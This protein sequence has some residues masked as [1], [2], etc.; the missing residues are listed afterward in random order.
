MSE[1]ERILDDMEAPNQPTY[2]QR[3]VAELDSIAAAFA[4]IL[5]ASAINNVE[6]NRG[7][8]GSGMVFLGFAKWG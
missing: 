8:G 4:D 1:A 6:P 2:A 5:N 3:V 7:L